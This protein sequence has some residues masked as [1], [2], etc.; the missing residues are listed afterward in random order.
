MVTVLSQ[1]LPYGSI[2]ACC[3]GQT[4]DARHNERNCVI[5]R[6]NQ[7]QYCHRQLVEGTSPE[8]TIIAN[9][10]RNINVLSEHSARLPERCSWKLIVVGHQLPRDF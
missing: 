8:S 7:R 1:R 3:R 10:Y 9:R 5:F 6:S 4:G 2:D